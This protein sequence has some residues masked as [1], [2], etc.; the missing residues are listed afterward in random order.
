[1]DHLVPQELSVHRGHQAKWD[2]QEFVDIQEIR[3]G[4][5]I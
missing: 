5:L 1:M 3:Y 2:R 4:I